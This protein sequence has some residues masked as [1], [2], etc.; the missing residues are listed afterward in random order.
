MDYATM[1]T[2]NKLLNDDG[3]PT[4]ATA[5]A[6]GGGIGFLVGGLNYA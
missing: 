5:Q 2:N 6:V 4:T 1:L 3:T